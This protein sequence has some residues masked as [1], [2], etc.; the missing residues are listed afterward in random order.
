VIK[1]I[2]RSNRRKPME[3]P[4]CR[5]AFTFFKRLPAEIRRLV[6]KY[7]LPGPRVLTH[8]ALHN[9]R[10]SLLNVCRESREVVKL[11]YVRLLRARSGFDLL[12][13][14]AAVLWANP[15]FDTIVIDLTAPQTEES[16][17]DILSCFLFSLDDQKF[18]TQIFRPLIGLSRVKHLALAF[19]LIHDNGGALFIALQA[20]FPDLQ[21][22][23]VFPN[24]QMH[25]SARDQH[26]LWGEEDL[27]FVDVDSNLTDYA[28]FRHDLLPERRYKKKSFRG[29]EILYHL[30]DVARQYV[31]VFPEHIQRHSLR[32]GQEWSP[33][34]RLCLLASKKQP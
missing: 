6:W 26:K 14:P 9:S 25:V 19:N 13:N 2:I 23:T 10:L 16:G 22:L 34:V 1:F 11:S 33:S 5:G 4:S 7:A 20:A 3:N 21:T 32:I 8:S 29:L 30:N 17:S 31:S 27:H 15:E 18:M 12:E 28:F 24:S